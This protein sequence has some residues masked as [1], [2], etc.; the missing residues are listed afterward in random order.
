MRCLCHAHV[1]RLGWFFDKIH[2]D[3]PLPSLCQRGCSDPPT[4]VTVALSDRPRFSERLRRS[5]WVVGGGGNDGALNA[6]GRGFSALNAGLPSQS[7]PLI[8]TVE[9]HPEP[10]SAADFPDPASWDVA[11]ALTAS[12]TEERTAGTDGTAAATATGSSSGGVS[13]A[14]STEPGSRRLVVAEAPSVAGEGYQ[15]GRWLWEWH[16]V[17]CGNRASVG[18]CRRDV[19]AI[20]A[21]GVPVQ[22]AGGGGAGD[23]ADLWL[24]RSDGNLSHGGESTERMCPGGGFDSGDVVGV[25][26][27]ADAGTLAFLKNDTYV[28]GQFKIDRRSEGDDNDNGDGEGGRGLYPCVSLRGSGDAAVLLGLKHGAATITYRSPPSEKKNGGRS[29]PSP[30]PSPSGEPEPTALAASVTADAEAA[31]AAAAATVG[32]GDLAALADAEAAV[33]A[34]REAADAR[35]S[36]E[37]PASSSSGTAGDS[38]AAAAAEPS[39]GAEADEGSS[40]GAAADGGVAAEGA[41][42][43]SSSSAEPAAAAAS[44]SPSP[45]PPPSP[46]PAA[47]V[48][49]ALPTPPFYPTYFHGEFVQGLKHGPGVLRL[50]GK[51]GYWRGKWFQGVQHGVHLLVEPPSKKGQAEEDGSPTAWLFDR[52]VKVC[53]FFFFFCC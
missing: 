48:S 11:T 24:Y 44:P 46:P 15:T 49:T 35:P 10:P 43:S 5:V 28:G 34:E 41:A 53:V 4:P 2:Q 51:G 42:S 6:A 13:G 47:A 33:A 14:G 19:A 32:G 9:V 45:P 1:S 25:E 3:V 23:R 22:G 31:A 18:V 12:A 50:S 16:I 20:S 39:P 7:G 36:P 52:G 40:G 37:K 8:A 30:P 26:L 29:S 38:T 17:S 21:A 27:D